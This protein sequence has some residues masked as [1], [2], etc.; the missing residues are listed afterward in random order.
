MHNTFAQRGQRWRPIWYYC[1][2]IRIERAFWGFL[3][4]LPIRLTIRAFRVVF[5][6]LSQSFFFRIQRSVRYDDFGYRFVIIS[7]CCSVGFIYEKWY[8]I[9][10]SGVTRISYS[11]GTFVLHTHILIYIYFFFS[12]RV[13]YTRAENNSEWKGWFEKWPSFENSAS[14]LLEHLPTITAY[15][16]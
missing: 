8:F 2:E 9:V 7:L 1:S 12:V 3:V 16:S 6:I 10:G 11:S 15:S 4:F 14:Y 13:S 5:P